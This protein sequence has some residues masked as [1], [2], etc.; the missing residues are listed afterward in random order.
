MSSLAGKD[1]DLPS[2]RQELDTFFIETAVWVAYLR[3][4]QS[5]SLEPKNW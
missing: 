3:S 2:C 5:F 4:T 1:H